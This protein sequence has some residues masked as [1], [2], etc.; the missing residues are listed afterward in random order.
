MTNNI[1]P[2]MAQAMIDMYYASQRPMDRV[3]LKYDPAVGFVAIEHYDNGSEYRP[4]YGTGNTPEAAVKE[5][6]AQAL[7][8]KSLARVR[9]GRVSQFQPNF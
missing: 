1:D 2:R 4:T 3:E 9:G 6:I 5:A 7:A 8:A